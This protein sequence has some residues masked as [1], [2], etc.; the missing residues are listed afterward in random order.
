MATA[1]QAA[2]AVT[3]R[4]P[5]QAAQVS[6]GV[7]TAASVWSFTPAAQVVRGFDA[8]ARTRYVC[9]AA[10]ATQAAGAWFDAQR[11]GATNRQSASPDRARAA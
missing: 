11:A 4:R 2:S 10:A 9:P 8:S 5:D 6:L 1:A 3:R 7:L